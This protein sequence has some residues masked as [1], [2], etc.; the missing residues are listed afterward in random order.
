MKPKHFVPWIAPILLVG[1]VTY[2]FWHYYTAMSDSGDMRPWRALMTIKSL[3]QAA[4]SYYLHH[5]QWPPDLEILANP[6]P[7]GK[8]PFLKDASALI[9]PWGRPY[10]YDPKQINPKSEKPLIWCVPDPRT[11][12]IKITNWD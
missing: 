6:K 8:P 3:D 5:D 7:D 10:Q 4:T 9:D 1:A 11:P 2:G 12:E